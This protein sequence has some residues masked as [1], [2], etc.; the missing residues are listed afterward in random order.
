MG[1]CVCE[2]PASLLDILLLFSTPFDRL[3]LN[4]ELT[5]RLGG[6][7][8]WPPGSIVS[9]NSSIRPAGM[10]A[11]MWVLRIP[12]QVNLAALRG[13]LTTVVFALWKGQEF[14]EKCSASERT[15]QNAQAH[16]RSPGLAYSLGIYIVSHTLVKNKVVGP[17]PMVCTLQSQ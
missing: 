11:F 9:P 14:T 2:E 15:A 13:I 17:R 4:L 16:S 10:L 5:N 12:T 8:R 6:L 1:D 3:S 7:A